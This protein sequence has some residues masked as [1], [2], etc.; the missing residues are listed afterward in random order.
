MGF[1]LFLGL[2]ILALILGWYFLFSN[3]KNVHYHEYKISSNQDKKN[4]KELEVLNTYSQVY[5]RT[6]QYIKTYKESYN[7]EQIRK[8]LT[9]A[10]IPKDII[11]KLFE[12]L[13]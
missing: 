7:K 3:N 9:D 2:F 6:K 4:S 11:D 5:E 1:Y 13:Y 12:E 10:N 8:A